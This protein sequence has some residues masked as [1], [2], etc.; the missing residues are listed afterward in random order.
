MFSHFTT[1]CM[2]GSNKLAAFSCRFVKACVTFLLPP[3]TNGLILAFDRSVL[4][5]N[6]TLSKLVL[7]T[8]NGTPVFQKRFLF[9]R[10]FVSKLKYWNVQNFQ[11]LSHK[12]NTDL[13]NGG[14]S[15]KSLVP[16]LEEPKVF[17]LIVRE[18]AFVVKCVERSIRSNHP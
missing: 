2:Q 5:G 9:F 8:R 16:F 17:L 7:S 12:N 18:K 6:V 15:L 14:L 11:W 3:G 13:V 1:L 4:Y 10:K